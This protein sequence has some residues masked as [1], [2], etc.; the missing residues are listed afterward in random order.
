[1]IEGSSLRSEGKKF[2]SS[3]EFTSA[4]DSL[5]KAKQEQTKKAQ[6]EKSKSPEVVAKRKSVLQR[7]DERTEKILEKRKKVA[8]AR[9]AILNA[10]PLKYKTGEDIAKGLAE[11]GAT[12][13]KQK[14]DRGRAEAS[15]KR[16]IERFEKRTDKLSEVRASGEIEDTPDIHRPIPELSADSLAELDVIRNMGKPGEQLTEKQQQAGSRVPE[17]YIPQISDK[18][19]KNFTQY[20]DIKEQEEKM[21]SRHVGGSKQTAGIS[22]VVEI[23]P[24]YQKEIEMTEEPEITISYEDTE[25]LLAERRHTVNEQMAE[26][27]QKAYVE[28]YRKYD[29]GFTKG[30]P[31]DLVALTKPSIFAF[32]AQGKNL[33]KLYKE[34]EK[35]RTI[36]ARTSEDN[37]I[38]G[39]LISSEVK[40]TFKGQVSPELSAASK[41]SSQDAE[42]KEW[43]LDP[44]QVKA[45]AEIDSFTEERKFILPSLQ[46]IKKAAATVKPGFKSP[47]VEKFKVAGTAQEG[48][49]TVMKEKAL[50]IER[51][52][53]EIE[54]YFIDKK[55][56]EREDVREFLLGSE[57]TGWFKGKEKQMQKDYRTL[58]YDPALTAKETNR[59]Q[60]SKLKRP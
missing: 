46:E 9:A 2:S 33:K 5:V 12:I 58:Y 30:K 34:M 35:L 38:A 54:K 3:P 4:F 24:A 50:Q 49:D 59:Y 1:M 51:R 28:A 29:Q 26:E 60:N 7:V 6:I 45:N 43:F 36:A 11:A 32:G 19:V 14:S 53:R 41:A 56:A 17:N 57:I 25:D 40:N 16:M 37:K 10:G 55:M 8:E 27:A 52:L 42:E 48:I 47:L 31:D 44:K 18:K 13:E 39:N 22:S 21:Q 20:L 15:R 23:D